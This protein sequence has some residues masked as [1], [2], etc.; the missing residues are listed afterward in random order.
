M[1]WLAVPTWVANVLS[2]IVS[3]ATCNV[4]ATAFLQ[5]LW[6][7]MTGHR[8]ARCLVLRYSTAMSTAYLQPTLKPAHIPPPWCSHWSCQ[9][10]RPKTWGLLMTPGFRNPTSQPSTSSAYTYTCTCMHI[11]VG[12]LWEVSR[13]LGSPCSSVS[14][15]PG[16]SVS[17]EVVLLPRPCTVLDLCYGAVSAY[18]LEPPGDSRL[19]EQ[20]PCVYNGFTYKESLYFICSLLWLFSLLQVAWWHHFYWHARGLF[21]LLLLFLD[22]NP[23]LRGC[24]F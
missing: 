3:K 13:W 10:L 20:R 5:S 14:S 19:F 7:W 1:I 23:L 17:R 16:F 24:S 9:L 21:V 4:P 18:K 15:L 22:L 2:G 8:E 6:N 12:M 11:L